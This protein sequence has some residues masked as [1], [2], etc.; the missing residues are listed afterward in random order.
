MTDLGP[1]LEAV[2]DEWERGKTIAQRAGIDSRTAGP[3][4][5]TLVRQ[6]FVV[7][8]DNPTPRTNNDRVKVYR[9]GPKAPPA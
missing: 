8:S 7:A 6:G 2:T 3:R 9:R 1:L 5:A 4:L